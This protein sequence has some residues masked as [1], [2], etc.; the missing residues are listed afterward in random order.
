MLNESHIMVHKARAFF[1]VSPRI[2]RPCRRAFAVR[3]GSRAALMRDGGPRDSLRE[4]FSPAMLARFCARARTPWERYRLRILTASGPDPENPYRKERVRGY[5]A[6]KASWEAYLDGAFAS[7]ALDGS[8][9]RERLSR[10]T[11]FDE[12]QFWSAM[13]EC[14]AIWFFCGKLGYRVTGSARGR[15]AHE[16]EFTVHLGHSRLAVEVKAPFIPIL[17]GAR[18]GDDSPSLQ[19]ALKRANRQFAAKRLNLLV[20]APIGDLRLYSDR[21][22]L[23]EAFFGDYFP[24]F[25]IDTTTGHPTGESGMTFRETGHFLSRVRTGGI[26]FKADGSPRFT[27]VGGVLSLEPLLVHETMEHNALLVHNPHARRRLP[28]TAW[29]DIPQFV[30]R[31]FMGWTDGEDSPIILDLERRMVRP[32]SQLRRP[33]GHSGAGKIGRPRAPRRR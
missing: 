4:V 25:V 6:I 13:A 8:S 14:M 26:P 12:R 24:Y 5:K 31:T 7:G 9:G 16:L 32:N 10:L 19:R 21:S 1:Y 3:K 18:R 15:G 30:A 28:E 2:L 29:F 33:T 17:Q 27:R 20:I 22:Q 23:T 11:G